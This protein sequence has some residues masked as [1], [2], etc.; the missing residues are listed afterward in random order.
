MRCTASWLSTF[1]LEG[2]E[3]KDLDALA[4]PVEVTTNTTIC[5]QGPNERH[6]EDMNTVYWCNDTVRSGSVPY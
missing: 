6:S 4:N 2:C 3:R 5:R 1:D